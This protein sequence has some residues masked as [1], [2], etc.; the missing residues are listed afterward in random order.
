MV[1]FSCYV[2]WA[3]G[4]GPSGWLAGAGGGWAGECLTELRVLV[5]LRWR[6]RWCVRLV[7]GSC[8]CHLFVSYRLGRA[9]VHSRR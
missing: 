3:G 1:T 9:D 8:V 2:A 6:L 5:R 4:G 7:P